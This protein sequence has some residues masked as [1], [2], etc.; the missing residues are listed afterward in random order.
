MR[1]LGRSGSGHGEGAALLGLVVALEAVEVAARA[2]GRVGSDAH[3]PRS[4]GAGGQFVRE[5]A[6]ELRVGLAVVDLLVVSA[7]RGGLWRQDGAADVIAW[8]PHLEPGD[9]GAEG[10]LEVEIGVGV[11]LV[12]AEA[13]GALQSRVA[14]VRR[15]SPR[16]LA[17]R[18]F[19]GDLARGQLAVVVLV[20]LLDLGRSV[21][22]GD[23]PPAAAGV[24]GEA[25]RDREVRCLP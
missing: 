15:E 21:A 2:G 12:E 23:H 7:A 14:R 1:P 11:A 16:A 5:H 8:D 4:L 9:G 17:R 18:R 20:R 3:G 6:I 13:P 24:V 25:A 22:A 10:H 19:Y